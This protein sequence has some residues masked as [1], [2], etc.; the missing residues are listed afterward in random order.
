MAF[1]Y[2]GHYKVKIDS[3]FSASFCELM[4][5]M[6]ESGSYTFCFV[7]VYRML[8]S[9]SN[10]LQKSQFIDDL[11]DYL[12]LAAN[13]PGRLLLVGNFNVHWDWKDDHEC[14]QL[15]TVLDSYNVIQHVSGPT[16]KATHTVDLVISRAEENLVT[17]CDI[18]ECVSDHNALNVTLN[19]CKEHPPRT[20][21]SY[22]NLKSMNLVAFSQSIE[23]S[24]LVKPIPDSLDAAVNVYQA[25]LEK[26][27]DIH[28]PI[29]HRAVVDHPC[30]PWI[31]AEILYKKREKRKAEKK[32]A[33]KWIYKGS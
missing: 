1:L 30:Q 9:T 8:S 21:V 23:S 12:E 7:V 13:L 25:T 11:A 4:T 2:R 5:V 10:K 20:I 28:A 14:K 6:L 3:S 19:C 22:R 32:N 26:L 15:M 17:S 24:D 29:K 16:H 31:T 27:L 33:K 18:G